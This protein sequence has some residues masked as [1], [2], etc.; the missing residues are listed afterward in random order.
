MNK[1]LVTV[2]IPTRNSARTLTK[3]LNSVCDQTYSNLEVNIID[4]G[5]VDKTIEICQMFVRARKIKL[6]VIVCTKGSLLT[7]REKGTKVARGKY[8]LI[9][10]SDQILDKQ[11]IEKGV[12][13]F[14]KGTY[15]M[16]ALEEH[17]YRTDNFIEK[18]FEMDRRLIEKV[19]D[20]DPYTGVILPRFYRTN[21]LRRAFNQIP[22]KMLDTLGGPDHAV[23][24]FEAW[25]LS[26]KV[27]ILPKAVFHIEPNSLLGI[28]K[29]FFRWGYTG[30]S[31]RYG[32]YRQL[33]ERKERF[34]T[35]MFT[36]GMMLES[37]ASLYLLLMKGLPYKIGYFYGILK[38]KFN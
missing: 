5:S 24:Y 2:S 15:D 1:P 10:D 38:R 23:I 9:L 34:R 16:L 6:E 17:S 36:N 35:G 13:F 33:M 7:A 32:K 12:T 19:K 18:M 22:K 4:A 31:A 21:L 8:L 30:V 11:T 29:K 20:L 14:E 28:W 27:G 3:T 26:T 25:S 37:F